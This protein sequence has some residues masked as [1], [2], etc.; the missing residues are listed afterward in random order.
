MGPGLEAKAV[1]ALIK[2]DCPCPFSCSTIDLGVNL[3]GS[4]LVSSRARYYMS[5]MEA[6]ESEILHCDGLFLDNGQETRLPEYRFKR[7]SEE[8]KTIRLTDCHAAMLSTIHKARLIGLEIAYRKE[9]FFRR[10][11]K[12][13]TLQD[14]PRE[15]DHHLSLMSNHLGDALDVLPPKPMYGRLTHVL[16]TL[17]GVDKDFSE[18]SGTYLA[19]FQDD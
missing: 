2:P 17:L 4:Q 16:R 9:P 13:F 6:F 19:L 1:T 7:M 8:D 14:V 18:S 5:R 11:F 10:K 3:P 12:D 15:F